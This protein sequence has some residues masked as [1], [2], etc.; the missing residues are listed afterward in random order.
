[1][2][3]TFITNSVVYIFTFTFFCLTISFT[4][5]LII[6]CTSTNIMTFTFPFSLIWAKNLR[7]T[8]TNLIRTTYWW[9]NKLICTYWFIINTWTK[10]ITNTMFITFTLDTTNLFITSMTIIL[11]TIINITGFPSIF[12]AMTYTR[13][14]CNTMFI[15]RT[16]NITFIFFRF[17]ILLI[18]CTIVSVLFHTFTILYMTITLS[19]TNSK[20]HFSSFC[21]LLTIIFTKTYK[22]LSTFIF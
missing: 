7:L 12:I 9:T 17:F 2:A 8:R 13:T 4:Y 10:C 22:I 6:N 20:L 5:T 11:I 19:R 14:F 15:A 1:M 3:W 18:T 16:N 21:Y